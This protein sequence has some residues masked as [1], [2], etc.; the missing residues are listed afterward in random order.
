MDPKADAWLAANE[1]AQALRCFDQLLA[2]DPGD[3]EAIEGRAQALR[4]LGR[5]EEAD[6]ALRR[7]V[8]ASGGRAQLRV[9]NI[10][11]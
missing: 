8:A 4:R 7:V 3:V 1:P 9:E 2:R 10:R 5:D 6:D 11:R